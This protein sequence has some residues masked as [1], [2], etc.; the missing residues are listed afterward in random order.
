[1]DGQEKREK[2]RLNW[3]ILPFEKCTKRNAKS[4]P[5][6]LNPRPTHYE[7]VALPA[8]LRRHTGCEINKKKSGDE[9]SPDFF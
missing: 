7:C 8:E 3:M 9:P 5:R 4:L 1:M 6:D 2:G